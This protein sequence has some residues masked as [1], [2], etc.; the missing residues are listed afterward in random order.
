M[1]TAEI[2][3]QATFGATTYG[4]LRGGGMVFDVNLTNPNAQNRVV[5]ASCTT[6][7]TTFTVQPDVEALIISAHPTCTAQWQV[8]LQSVQSTVNGIVLTS[9]GSLVLLKPMT[10]SVLGVQASSNGTTA[11]VT[12]RFM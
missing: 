3:L 11:V 9:V 2:T 10:P 1:A 12:V 8:T 6:A 7:G 5:Q 4:N